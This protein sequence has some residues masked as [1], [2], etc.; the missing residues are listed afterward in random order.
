[1]HSLGL[2][3]SEASHCSR[4]GEA[5]S[6]SRGTHWIEFTVSSSSL[7]RKEY[8]LVCSLHSSSVSRAFPDIWF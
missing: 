6:L 1:M 2:E 5:K 4:F 8:R 3:V 7:D